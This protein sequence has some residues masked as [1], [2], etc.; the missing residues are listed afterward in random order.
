VLLRL[1]V[2]PGVLAAPDSDFRT[3]WGRENCILWGRT[4]HADFGPFTHTL[5]IRAAWGGIEHCH[6][7]GRTIGVD[8]DNFLILN[9]G[10]IYSTSVRSELP[11]ET[12][13]ICF[14][15]ALVEQIHFEGGTSQFLEH[16]RPHDAVVSPLLQSIRAAMASGGTD[17]LWFDEQLTSLLARMRLHQENLLDRVENLALIR[18]TTRREVYRRVSRATDL[19]HSNYA[20]GVDLQMLAQTA[21]LSKYHFLR[22][23]KLVHGLTPHTYLQRKRVCVAVRLL[24][25]TRLTMREVATNVGFADDS[26]LVPQVRRWTRRTPGQ[27]RAAAAS[28]AVDQAS[29]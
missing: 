25:S 9:H 24:E 27:V 18:A 28:I 13:A 10:R 26:T 5:S 14:D 29:A 20:S 2:D 19:L 15:P 4:R 23:F 12:L 21:G 3:R 11:V 8:D 16:L 6:T 22:L 7:D 17:E 1:P